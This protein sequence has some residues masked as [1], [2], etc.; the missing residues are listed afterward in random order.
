MNKEDEIPA[1][2]R[3]LKLC[4]Y[5]DDA[6]QAINEL[7][8]NEFIYKKGST[9][10]YIFKTRAGSELRAEIRRRGELKGDNV[11]YTKVLLD[12]TGK[13]YVIPRK[14]N[15]EKSMTRYFSNEFMSVDDFLSIGSVSY[16]H[17]TLPTNREV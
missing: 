11:N 3:Y 13:Y 2:R 7:K 5:A 8:E 16:T 9:D 17:L 15:T 6:D 14:Y 12:V 4:V 1:T 10:T